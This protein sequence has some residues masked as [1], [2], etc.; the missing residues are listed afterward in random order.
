M[1]EKANTYVLD[2]YNLTSIPVD[3]LV[4]APKAPACTT[5]SMFPR[6]IGPGGDILPNSSKTW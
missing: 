3:G 2:G 5:V 4:H 1:V 6:R